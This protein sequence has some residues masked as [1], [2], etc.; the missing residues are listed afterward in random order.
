MPGSTDALVEYALGRTAAP[1]AHAVVR[2]LIDTVGVTLA[3]F[4]S[5]VLEA[6]Q[7]WSATEPT[8]GAAL[9]WGQATTTSPGRAAL[10]NGAAAHA[11]DFDDA[12]PSM[13]MHPSAVI[14]PAVLAWSD[15]HD[16]ETDAVLRAVD[17]GQAVFRAIGEALPMKDHYA[18]GWHSTGTI[19]RIAAT[20]ALVHL[21]GLDAPAARSAFGIAATTAA[22]SQA[23][24]GTMTK[25]VHAGQAAQDAVFAVGMA[26]A[27][28]DAHPNQLDHSKGYFALF[29]VGDR[30][31]SDLAERL[32]YW[33]TAWVDE[34]SLK[35][36]PACYGTHRAVDALLELRADF[37]VRAD[38]VVRID[39]CVHPSGLDPLID[40]L[41]TTALE[42]KFSLPYT[43]VRT[44]L[45]GRLDL[46]AFTDS[47]VNAPGVR[48]W[49]ERVALSTASAPVGQPELEG[50]LFAQVAVELTNG[51]RLQ[52]TVT[53][54][55]GDA[56]NPLDDRAIDD[57]FLA[58]ARAAGWSEGA[59]VNL[60]TAMHA[61]GHGGA[62][63]TLRNALRHDPEDL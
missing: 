23:N 55:R 50:Q 51:E 49:M 31:R 53:V 48:D 47:E 46:D 1:Q 6:L 58:C 52:R 37:D 19:G 54:T 39:V 40:H 3:G 28:L 4:D 56:R 20:A 26:L 62:M 10:L 25:P 34:W 17:I 2:S 13:P 57:K 43:M 45:D 38:D 22:G 18:R 35:R 42:G 59:A 36:Y 14:W 11:L 33:Q 27:G 44:L 63:T 15:A 12:A 21:A 16:C 9:V 29:G 60:L 7:R 41:P 5:D 8:T 32:A 30:D 24:F 61:L